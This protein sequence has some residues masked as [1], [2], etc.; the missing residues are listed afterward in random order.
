[1]AGE[2][3]EAAG[4]EGKRQAVWGRDVCCHGDIGGRDERGGEA[5]GKELK[6][7]SGAG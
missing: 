5:S 1:M 2:L 6:A 7:A 3:D 4:D